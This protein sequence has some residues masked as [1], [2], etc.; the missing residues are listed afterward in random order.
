[1]KHME[2]LNQPAIAF[3]AMIM[4]MPSSAFAQGSESSLQFKKEK[5]VVKVKSEEQLKDVAA[6]LSKLQSDVEVLT[7]DVQK[8]KQRIMEDARINNVI[9]IDLGLSN[10]DKATIRNLIVRVDGYNVY[11]VSETTGLWLPTKQIPIYHGPLEPGVH[12]VEFDVSLVLRRQDGVPLNSDIY[13]VVKAAYN[14]EVPTGTL[15][16]RWLAM[17]GVPNDQ[18]GKATLEFRED[19]F[20]KPA[21]IAAALPEG[22]VPPTMGPLIP[23]AAPE[24]RMPVATV[25]PAASEPTPAIDGVTILSPKEE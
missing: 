17:V 14:I 11:W 3:L 2:R 9:S 24:P 16:K 23:N 15:K 18:A 13:R 7:S 19:L 21:D 12:R 6:A 8:A 25:L 1:M 4:L 20:A 10:T 5:V 22:E